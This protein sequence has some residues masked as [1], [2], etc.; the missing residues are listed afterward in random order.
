MTR[1]ESYKIFWLVGESSA[2]LHSELVMKALNDKFG[3]LTHI[4]IGGPRMQRQ[5]LKPLF[6]FERFAVMG[7]VEVVKHLFFFFKVEHK[8]SKLFAT[9]EF[10][11]FIFVY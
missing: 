2:D 1:K 3:N 7:F 8:L 4:G 6:P 10:Y 5:G 11:L 9:E